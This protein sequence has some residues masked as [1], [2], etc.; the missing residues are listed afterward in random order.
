MA[1]ND[2]ITKDELLDALRVSAADA[3]VTLRGLAPAAFSEG[4]YENGWDARQILAHLAAIEWTYPRLGASHK[5]QGLKLRLF[6]LSLFTIVAVIGRPSDPVS[7]LSGAFSVMPSAYVGGG[8]VTHGG[9]HFDDGSR[10]A[11]DFSHSDSAWLRGTVTTT[12][13]NVKRYQYWNEGS[14]L[15][16]ARLQLY[17]P[18]TAQWYDD[19]SADVHILHLNS[20]P[21]GTSYSQNFQLAYYWFYKVLG[22][23]STCGA[24]AA[25][26]HLAM[27]LSSMVSKTSKSNDTCW[28]KW[29]GVQRYGRCLGECPC[30][31]PSATIR[32]R[33]SL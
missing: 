24:Y 31:Q 26:S 20:M 9:L 19:Y 2:T 11:Y 18:W 27:T 14:C 3:L 21:A 30:Q 7:A 17:D 12:L 13:N 8:N 28:A 4:R 5:F 15:M 1:A 16:R 25:H 32:R 22:T 33:S 23:A 6:L 10:A 29:N